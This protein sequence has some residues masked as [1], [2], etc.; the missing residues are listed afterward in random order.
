MSGKVLYRKYRPTKLEDVVGQTSVTNALQNAI[1]QHKIGHAYLFIGPRGTGKTSVA[2]IFAHAINKFK[3]TVEDSYLDIIEI[4]AASNT[5]VDNIRELREKAV[6]A[7]TKGKYKVY[8]IDEVHM[9][10]KSASNALLKTLEEPP[11][12][13]IFIMATT[14]AHKVPIT[15]SSRTQ[16]FTFQLADPD[17][18]FQHLRNVANREKIPITDGALKLIVR[19]GGGSFRDSMSL[20]D[21]ATTLTD[22]EIT[23]EILSQALGLPQD[24]LLTDLLHAYNAGD[25][26]T[27][28]TLLQTLLNTGIKPEII[29]SELISRIIAEPQPA[30]LSLLAKLPDVQPPF[31]EAK[32]LLALLSNVPTPSGPAV[33]SSATPAVP[34]AKAESVASSS[35]ILNSDAPTQK[36]NKTEQTSSETSKTRLHSASSEP[37]TEQNRTKPAV[38]SSTPE[39]PTAFPA[40]APSASEPSATAP[41]PSTTTPEPSLAAPALESTKPGDTVNELLESPAT[42]QS[43]ET[44]VA[45][46]TTFEWGTFLESVRA[47]SDGVYQQLR[48]VEYELVD[49]T[50]H[51]Y[52]SNKFTKSVLEKPAHSQCLAKHLGNIALVLHELGE[53]QSPKDE[54]LSKIS[55]IM[56]DIQEVKGDLPF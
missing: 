21:Q 31:P 19:R 9:L 10:T 4:D 2:R 40:P 43:E 46:P 18:M 11:E 36:P 23:E 56:G 15:I 34:S 55:D 24:Q 27:I 35:N 22:A 5:G 1:K 25:L 41:K 14:D 13:V 37:K 47:D 3:Y 53:R 42:Q 20:L 49:T 12:H 28:R 26:N 50:L 45:S 52:P 6:I 33:A 8:I 54:T 51:L 32:L 48:K 7:P 16:V 30:W 38:A 39:P 17:T 44:P 29:A